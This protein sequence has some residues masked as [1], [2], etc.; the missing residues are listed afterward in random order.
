MKS[1]ALNSLF[2]SRSEFSSSL[3]NTKHQRQSR[4]EQAQEDGVDA[5][6]REAESEDDFDVKDKSEESSDF[7]NEDKWI[8][9]V[10]EDQYDIDTT[11]FYPNKKRRVRKGK[12]LL[13]TAEA[14]LHFLSIWFEY[15]NTYR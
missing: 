15:L 10:Q 14:H 7:E 6:E 1:G 8:A 5:D 9:S 4:P 2:I 11:T 3:A 12:A 13:W